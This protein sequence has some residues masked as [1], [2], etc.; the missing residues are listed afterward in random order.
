MTNNEY[1]VLER[2]SIQSENEEIDI[3]Y[4]DIDTTP[5]TIPKL[6]FLFSKAFKKTTFVIGY[7]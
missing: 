5:L 2:Y 1:L 6:N 7:K 4:K 3:D